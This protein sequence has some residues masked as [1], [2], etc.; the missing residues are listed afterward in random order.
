MRIY[1]SGTDYNVVSGNF[2][3][4]DVNGTAKQPN[5]GSGVAVLWDAQY[6]RIGGSQPGEGNVLSGDDGLGFSLDGTDVMSNTVVGN[7]L[8]TD[9]TGMLALGNG[10]DGI[11][12][13]Q[14]A[15]HNVFGGCR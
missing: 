5:R 7:R 9:V 3:G 15:Q 1:G 2:V 10:K 13:I 14:G 8:G 12:L 4:T 11:W 6:N